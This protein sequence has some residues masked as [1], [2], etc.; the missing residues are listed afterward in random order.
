MK[1]II[2][3]LLF[4]AIQVSASTELR[5][6]ILGGYKENMKMIETERGEVRENGDFLCEYKGVTETTVLSIDSGVYTFYKKE[7]SN[8]YCK[9][10]VEEEIYISTFDLFTNSINNF[11]NR[12][13]DQNLEFSFDAKTKVF[14]MKND[15]KSMS[16]D[17]ADA[18][19]MEAFGAKLTLGGESSGGG[20]VTTHGAPEYREVFDVELPEI[21]DDIIV[22]DE[23]LDSDLTDDNIS[24]EEICR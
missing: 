13:D 12:T 9:E 14:A 16:L 8:R 22:C 1:F 2:F 19:T 20:F 4:S 24:S 6:H 23:R 5:D 15:S 10:T 17:V 3:G 11:M 21:R 18:R 7:T